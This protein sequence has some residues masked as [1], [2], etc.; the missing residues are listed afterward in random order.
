MYTLHITIHVRRGFL[1][2]KER[3][4]YEEGIRRQQTLV[5]RMKQNV[6]GLE[7]WQCS[8]RNVARHAILERS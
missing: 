7:I 5:M 4:A 3:G 8:E 1:A 2:V 6:G